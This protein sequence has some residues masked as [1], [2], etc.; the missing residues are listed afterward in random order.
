MK[1][2]QTIRGTLLSTGLFL[3]IGSAQ[4]QLAPGLLAYWNFENDALDQAPA[5]PGT[6][7]TSAD[8]GTINGGVTLSLIH[9]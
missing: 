5:T 8:D 9:I 1:I 2:K 7:G 4:A 3:S 6:S